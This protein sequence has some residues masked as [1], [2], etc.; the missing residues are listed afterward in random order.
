LLSDF[1]ECYCGE[2]ITGHARET[3]GRKVYQ[4][5]SKH[6]YW[7]GKNVAEC[8]NRRSMN[9]NLTDE[10]VVSQVK[11]VMGNSSIL[12]EKFKTDVMSQKSID[13][14]QID[15]E[16]KMRENKIKKLDNQIDLTV[17]S[18][19]TNEVNHILKKTDDAIYQQIKKT[20]DEEKASLDDAK[21]Q[22]VEEI[23]ELGNKK[24][25]IDWITRYGDDIS[26]RFEKPI[27]KINFM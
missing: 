7:K 16:K 4:C 9:M 24:D 2:K 26:K 19:S 14:S 6:N 12:K 3:V 1:L 23:N 8:N 11:D 13:S 22:F 27:F 10:F 17:K 15:L 20:L 5:A 18:I 21:S 25:W